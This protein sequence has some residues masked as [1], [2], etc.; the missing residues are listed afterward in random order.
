MSQE[1]GLRGNQIQLAT[2]EDILFLLKMADGEQSE[3]ADRC[4]IALGKP[5]VI[6]AGEND[7]AH[8]RPRPT[9]TGISYS[10]KT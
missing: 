10:K 6:V 3:V 4:R 2:R 8:V 9:V 5:A 7:L 1:S